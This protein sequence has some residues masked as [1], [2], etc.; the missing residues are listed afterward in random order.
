MGFNYA[1]VLMKNPKTKLMEV[2]ARAVNQE[3]TTRELYSLVAKK[4]TLTPTDVAACIETFLEEVIDAMRSSK[5]IRLG[6]FGSFY[7]TLQ[8]EAS[9]KEDS[10][11]TAMIR[12]IRVRFSPKALLKDEVNKDVDYV[13]TITKKAEA[14][15]KKAAT[16]S[17]NA[18]LHAQTVNQDDGE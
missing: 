12:R 16:E 17:Q 14:A 3:M 18:A 10:F 4:T 11:N 1:T 8:S 7:P 6:D 13:K 15:A 9:K 2:R 5:I